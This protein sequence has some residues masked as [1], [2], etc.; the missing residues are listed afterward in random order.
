MRLLKKKHNIKIIYHCFLAG[1]WK[2]VISGQLRR[3]KESGLYHNANDIFLTV[4][5]GDSSV[6]EFKNL[7]SD[8]DKLQI[9]FTGENNFEYEGIKKV[10]EQAFIEDCFIF[11]FHAKGVSNS[12][13][14]LKN[15]EFS[16]AK[17]ESVEGWRRCM[18]YFLIDNWRDC[19]DKLNEYDN[20]GVT[21][22]RGWYWG[23]FW[24]SKTAHIKKTKS[25]EISN[26]RWTYEDW[27]NNGVSDSKNYEFYHFD[28]NPYLGFVHEHVYK[29]K[30]NIK[31]KII[32]H[33]AYYGTPEFQIDE[34]FSD[35]NLNIKKDVT[36]IVMDLLRKQN[37]LKFS[38]E[39]NNDTMM[40]DPAYGCRKFLTVE[41]SYENNLEYVSK[42]SIPELI[43]FNF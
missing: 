7:V 15:R 9:N 24:W 13:K 35:Q 30:K 36:G 20:I 38:F 27:L 21:C 42:I 12:Y 32:L 3:L 28:F 33:R 5:I 22:N 37:N 40:G 41:F 31:D 4:N 6:E 8:Y 26:N 14:T 18:E 10:R 29:N 1:N 16:N 39:V 25:V 43:F 19:V 2:N 23:N 17:F 34:G 11:Y